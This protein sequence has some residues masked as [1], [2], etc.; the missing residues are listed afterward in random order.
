MTLQIRKIEANKAQ[1]WIIYLMA[2]LTHPNV[3]AYIQGRQCRVDNCPPDLGRIEGT[4]GLRRRAALLLAHP[5][6][7]GY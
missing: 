2:S 7:G 5:V 6:L 4:A 1:I 3:P